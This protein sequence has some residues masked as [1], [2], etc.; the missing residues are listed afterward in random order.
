VTEN[1]TQNSA[2]IPLFHIDFLLLEPFVHATATKIER[3]VSY[4]N[5]FDQYAS[6]GF[7]ING[8]GLLVISILVR[9]RTKYTALKL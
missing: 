2:A 7:A 8:I 9:C 4:L 6:L 1:R 5:V 3:K